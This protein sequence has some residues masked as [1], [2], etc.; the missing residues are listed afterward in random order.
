MFCIQVP[1]VREK[2]AG[3]EETE[4]TMAQ[5]A[6]DARNLNDGGSNNVS[7]CCICNGPQS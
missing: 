6:G 7:S 4:I 5:G 1:D 2:V 3:P